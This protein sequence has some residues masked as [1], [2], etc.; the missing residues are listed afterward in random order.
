MLMPN[1]LKLF[2]A[3]CLFLLHIP[4]EAAMELDAKIWVTGH[5]GLVGS[6]I[7]RNLQANGYQNLVLVDHESL[8]LCDQAAVNAFYSQEKPDYV[9]IAAAKVGGI[10]ANSTFPAEFIS[11]NL[12]IE[13]N[14]IHGA[15]LAQVKKLLFLGSSCIYPRECPQPI[16]EEYLLTLPLEP[17]NEWY[18]IAKIAGV[19]MC[20]AYSRQ[21]GVKFISLMPTN[22]YG[23]GDN[24]DLNNSHVLPA[25]IRKFVEAQESGKS[26][27][28]IWGSGRPMREFLYVDDLAKAVVWSM[29]N[30]EE[31]QWLNVGTG[32]DVTILQLAQMI[33]ESTG[34]S[35]RIVFDS[36]K[37]DGTPRKLLDVS[38]I[39]SLGWKAETS[40]SEGLKKTINSYKEQRL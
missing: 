9:I 22:L 7:V 23:P 29:N 11:V 38:K 3:A 1:P 15:Y 12:A 2:I 35:G 5:T 40:L 25:L 20:Q 19:K 30:Y 8:D 32:E 33:A 6:A 21:Y 27:V 34:Y 17:T 10:H 24:Y 36:S 28:V 31:E 13:R 26:E 4:S 16:K 39:N 14:L 18:A 37:P